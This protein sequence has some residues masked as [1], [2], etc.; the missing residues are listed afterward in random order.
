MRLYIFNSLII[1]K[2]TRNLVT[3]TK[4]FNIEKFQRSRDTANVCTQPND[5]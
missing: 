3:I 2:F 1:K 4:K 5:K